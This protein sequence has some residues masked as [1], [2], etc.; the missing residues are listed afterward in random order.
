MEQFN[1]ITIR[2]GKD[3]IPDIQNINSS[4]TGIQKVP[5]TII[6]KCTQIPE[7]YGKGDYAFLW[8]G[9]DNNKGVSTQWKQGF[10]AV[11]RVIKVIRGDY[12]M[13]K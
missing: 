6:V 7:N 3:S 8:L 1:F 4:T 5:F 11:G 9:S 2:L 10:K 13:I 12:I